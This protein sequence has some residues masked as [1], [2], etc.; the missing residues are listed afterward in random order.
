MPKVT[1][2]YTAANQ[3]IENKCVVSFR[4]F[5]GADYQSL[6]TAIKSLTVATLYLT[7]RAVPC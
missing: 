1:D 7:R 5:G 6:L 2:G 3:Q 4:G